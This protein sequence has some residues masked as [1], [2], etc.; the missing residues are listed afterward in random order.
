MREED[1]EAQEG[2]Q[3]VEGDCGEGQAAGGLE[4]TREKV[5]VGRGRAGLDG[6]TVESQR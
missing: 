3:I 5:K 6:D 4:D 2:E 1:G